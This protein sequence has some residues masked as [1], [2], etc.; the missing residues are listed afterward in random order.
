MI[1][2]E[3]PGIKT[4]N[5]R[6]LVLDYNGTL[7]KDG[8]ILP[9]VKE[10]LNQLS[11][12]LSI[13]IITADTF[14]NVKSYIEDIKCECVI[15]SGESQGKQKLEFV[16]KLGSSEV[17]AIGNG[18]NDALMIK[19]AVL[20]IAIIQQE[21]ASVNSI[22]NADIVCTNILDALDLLLNPL[23]VKASLRD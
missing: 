17:I 20:G 12:V 4:I 3:I 21:G 5:A 9:Y 18:A 10:K 1:K 7:A 14:G 11:K 13:Y 22:L 16:R 8:I 6:F 19:D 2:F 23:R 15:I